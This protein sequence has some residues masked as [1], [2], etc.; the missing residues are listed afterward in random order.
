MWLMSIRTILLTNFY[1]HL[2]MYSSEKGANSSTD[3]I[4]CLV[5]STRGLRM[6][7]A[8]TNYSFLLLWSESWTSLTNL[9]TVWST[10]ESR[11]FYRRSV[12]QRG[13]MLSSVFESCT[14]CDLW[15]RFERLKL[16][17]M[18]TRET[19]Q[20]NQVI[21]SSSPV[22]LLL[23][24]SNFWNYWISILTNFLNSAYRS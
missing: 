23:V 1:R 6:S 14:S 18:L 5:Y 8:G 9:S 11:S 24:S 13:T 17:V 15:I 10:L 19:T 20:S 21:L 12:I 7:A 4:C 22:P 3:W 16:W 2:L